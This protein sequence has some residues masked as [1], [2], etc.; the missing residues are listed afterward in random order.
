MDKKMWWPLLRGVPTVTGLPD[1]T[2][3]ASSGAIKVGRRATQR[4]LPFRIRLVRTY[5]H[6]VRAV[7]VRRDAY[8][9]HL[10]AL[11]DILA[12]AERSD[13]TANS[14]VLLAE[15][16]ADGEAIGTMRIATNLD[17]PIEFEA[18]L[19]LPACFRGTTI[20]QVARL[21]VRNCTDAALVKLALFK[22]L[23]RYCLALQIEWMMVGAHPPLDRLYQQ[24]RFIDVFNPEDRFRI[25]SAPAY[26][27]RVMAFAVESAERTWREADHPLYDFMFAEYCPDIEIFNSVSSMW[28]R[29]RRT[30]QEP[31]A[32]KEPADRV[33]S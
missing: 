18:A 22:A 12:E 31:T 21:G 3:V 8:A 13:C 20:A 6:L 26:D 15:S 19:D 16:K 5:E 4:S 17:A 11:A 32:L 10:P 14:V 29:P 27:V 30:E 24:L 1:L 23:H 25:P 28:A 7:Q 9:R 2:D 33:F